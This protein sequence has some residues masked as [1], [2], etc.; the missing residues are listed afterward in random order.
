MSSIYI[1]NKYLDLDFW[2]E[3]YGVLDV[4]HDGGD[5]TEDEA[6]FSCS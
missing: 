2:A 3:S 1:Y 6:H 5:V 4:V